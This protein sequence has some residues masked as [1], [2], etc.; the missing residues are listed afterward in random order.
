MKLRNIV[1]GSVLGS[2]VLYGGFL[3]GDV[4]FSSLLE[5]SKRQVQE[6]E[7]AFKASEIPIHATV[8]NETYIP[9]S[10]NFGS[11]YV[12]K[13]QTKEGRVLGINVTDRLTGITKENLDALVSKES[14]VSFP[15]GNLISRKSSYSYPHGDDTYFAEKTQLGNKRVDRITVLK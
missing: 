3:G 5:S 15:S 4:I 9:A 13:V 1:L 12:L 14:E 10:V 8:L 6:Q 11:F 2:S 7:E